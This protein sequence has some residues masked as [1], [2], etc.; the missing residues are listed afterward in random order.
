MRARGAE[1]GF[2]AKV[3]GAWYALW[4]MRVLPWFVGCA[5][6]VGCSKPPAEAETPPA[7]DAGSGQK[8]KPT[9]VTLL[10]TGAENGYLLPT[11]DETGQVQ[12]GAAEVLGRWVAT[13]GHCAGALGPNGEAAC[14][15]ARTVVLST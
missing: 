15:E 2:A 11:A 14:P 12:G 6:A 3:P 10:I 4:F 5:L 13:D 9:E 7:V 8:P 1:L